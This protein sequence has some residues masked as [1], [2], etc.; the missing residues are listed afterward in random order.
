[1][2]TIHGTLQGG[3]VVLDSLP[4]LPDGSRVVV[5]VSEEESPSWGISEEEWPKTEQEIAEWVAWNDSR[6]PVEITPEGEE[7]LR[8][9]REA[10]RKVT[11]E[12]VRRRMGLGE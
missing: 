2:S 5:F 11:L 6:E 7:E 1:M 8:Q 3:R 9:A 12:A 4:D 10:V